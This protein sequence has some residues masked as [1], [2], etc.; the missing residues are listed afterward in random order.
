MRIIFSFCAQSGPPP[1]WIAAT[2]VCHYWRTVA[3]EYPH[4]WS[5][6]S[7]RL[8]LHWVRIFM[9]RSAPLPLR[10]DLVGIRDPDTRSALAA[11]LLAVFPRVKTL[12]FTGSP[13][14][15]NFLIPTSDS[16]ESFFFFFFF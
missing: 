5:E 2:G 8:S 9:A 15:M 7:P 13:G 12:G 11:E 10:V 1:T 6:I 14:E 3:V 4:M 16:A